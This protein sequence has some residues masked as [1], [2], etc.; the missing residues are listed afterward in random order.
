[1]RQIKY[2]NKADREYSEVKKNLLNSL[3]SRWEQ[4]GEM[5]YNI[6]SANIEKL[7]KKFNKIKQHIFKNTPLFNKERINKPVNKCIVNG[8]I[9][10]YGDKTYNEEELIRYLFIDYLY[11]NYYECLTIINALPREEIVYDPADNFAS[12][13]HLLEYYALCKNYEKKKRIESNKTKHRIEKE[14]IPIISK[15]II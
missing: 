8:K 10:Y 5:D 7:E 1:M 15:T 6:Y 3:W 12:F 2:I 4:L 11:N 9:T 13:K 14:I